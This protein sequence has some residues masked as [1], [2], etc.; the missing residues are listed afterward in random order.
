M[1]S[2]MIYLAKALFVDRM[3]FLNRAIEKYIIVPAVS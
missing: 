3:Q 1:Y 2:T